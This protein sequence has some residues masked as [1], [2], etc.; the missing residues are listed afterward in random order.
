MSGSLSRRKRHTALEV[1]VW[2]RIIRELKFDKLDNRI[3]HLF[4]SVSRNVGRDVF[5]H[6]TTFIW[7]SVWSQEC[8]FWES[9][10]YKMPF[11]RNFMDASFAWSPI[12]R[13]SPCFQIE[14]GKRQQMIPGGVLETA[15][16]WYFKWVLLLWNSPYNASRGFFCKIC[17]FEE[18]KQTYYEIT[19]AP[20][21]KCH[22]L[23]RTTGW[24]PVSLINLIAAHVTQMNYKALLVDPKDSRPL[25][26]R[27]LRIIFRK[28][29]QG[30]IRGRSQDVVRREYTCCAKKA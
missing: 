20:T 22:E 10:T 4:A 2:F 1:M 5:H 26:Q 14:E 7:D 23:S 9:S 19:P 12:T 8:E 29:L 13:R 25:R 3:S 15:N 18:R 30:N 16:A 6:N 11:A 21:R 27:L 17:N 28:I 24:F